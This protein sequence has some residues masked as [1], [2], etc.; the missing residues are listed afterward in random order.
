M[1]RIFRQYSLHHSILGL[2]ILSKEWLFQ[3]TKRVGEA[4]NSQILIANA[5]FI[6]ECLLL[7]FRPL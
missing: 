1:L 4:L 5:W 3:I 6:F 2:S 7:A